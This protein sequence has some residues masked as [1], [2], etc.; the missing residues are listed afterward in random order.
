MLNVFMNLSNAV[1]SMIDAVLSRPLGK[2][3]NGKIYVSQTI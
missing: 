3:R 1:G 2:R